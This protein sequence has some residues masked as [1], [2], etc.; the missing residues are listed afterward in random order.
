[1]DLSRTL[2]TLVVGGPAGELLDLR[3]I[4]AA[5]VC[6]W[7]YFPDAPCFQIEGIMWVSCFLSP[8]VCQRLAQSSF[9]SSHPPAGAAGVDFM[10]LNYELSRQSVHISCAKTFCFISWYFLVGRSFFFF[11]SQG[12][13][14][15]YVN[16]WSKSQKNTVILCFVFVG[17]LICWNS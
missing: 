5:G 6:R 9:H 13:Y 16:N 14:H 3:R 1:M 10:Y 15:I 11:F 7:H 12:K 4:H 2:F 17:M 8:G